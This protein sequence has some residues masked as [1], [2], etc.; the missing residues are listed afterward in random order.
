MKNKRV[1]LVALGILLNSSLR[2]FCDSSEVIIY[3]ENHLPL[4][5]TLK[6]ITDDAK[7]EIENNSGRSS[8]SLSSK[9]L[10]IAERDW[11]TFSEILRASNFKQLS[12]KRFILPDLEIPWEAAAEEPLL[13]LWQS[14]SPLFEPKENAEARFILG[15]RIYPSGSVS[16]IIVMKA[17]RQTSELEASVIQNL[18]KLTLPPLPKNYTGP[19]IPFYIVIDKPRIERALILYQ[20]KEEL[21]QKIASSS[22]E[23]NPCQ[24]RLELIISSEGRL[25]QTEAFGSSKKAYSNYVA[26]TRADIKKLTEA[27]TSFNYQQIATVAAQ[28][29]NG[30]RKSVV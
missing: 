1:L 20:L 26:C 23:I 18:S 29:L 22:K 12:R 28:D 11:S 24:F 5:G 4:R 7:V 25:V 16:N 30:D 27:V 9:I 14:L 3:R 2:G 13:G 10:L 15:F 6:S 8:L 21:R 17:V 19:W